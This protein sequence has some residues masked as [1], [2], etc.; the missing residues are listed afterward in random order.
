[1]LKTTLICFYSVE[2]FLPGANP[3]QEQS[4]KTIPYL[5]IKQLETIPYLR[6]KQLETIPY[7]RIKQLETIPYL[8]IK[9]L[10]T[11]PFG[12]AHTYIA[13]IR[14]SNFP[15]PPY[16]HLHTGRR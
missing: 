15:P 8:R 1:M 10:E 6:I 7:L 13:H 9:Q 12:T 3:T 5:R 4:A 16:Y 14:E 11:I 2:W